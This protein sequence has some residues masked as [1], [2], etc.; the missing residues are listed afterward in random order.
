MF[1][2]KKITLKKYEF[3]LKMTIDDSVYLI[4]NV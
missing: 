3:A 1:L 4:A 2:Q